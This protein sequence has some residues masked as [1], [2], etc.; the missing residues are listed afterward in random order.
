MRAAE[1][2]RAAWFFG[3]LYE[4]LVGVPQL[5]DEAGAERG[6]GLLRAGSSVRYFA[7]VAPLAVGAT[8]FSLISR[9]R[10]HEGDRLLLA[11]EGRG[12]DRHQRVPYRRRQHFAAYAYGRTTL[13]STTAAHL[14]LAC[15]EHRPPRLP[16]HRTSGRATTAQTRVSIAEPSAGRRSG[17]GRK[18]P[19][20]GPSLVGCRSAVA[21]ASIGRVSAVALL[22]VLAAT[23]PRHGHDIQRIIAAWHLDR[24]ADLQPGSVYSGLTRL[25][26]RGSCARF[27]VE[28]DGNRPQRRFSP[29]LGRTIGPPPTGLGRKRS[30]YRAGQR[31]T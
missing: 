2:G 12:R 4:G 3:N 17:L 1:L 16:S 20:V 6:R 5:I 24:W 9:W 26:S 28:R 27:G 19:P 29:C 21:V 13:R 18:A 23:G 15:T 8:L 11:I 22:G 25:S 10:S 7:P 31:L 30:D 14:Y